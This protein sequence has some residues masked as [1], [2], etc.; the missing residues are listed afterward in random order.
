MRASTKLNVCTDNADVPWC[1][2]GQ[3]RGS[4][5]SNNF[6]NEP[7]IVVFQHFAALDSIPYIHFQ[8][9]DRKLLY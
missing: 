5:R 2:N 8:W 7:M 9:K 1:A 6:E 4:S 3:R